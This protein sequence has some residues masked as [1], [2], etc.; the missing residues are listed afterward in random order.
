MKRL[1]LMNLLFLFF[2]SLTSLYATSVFAQEVPEE[3]TD[4]DDKPKTPVKRD[5]IYVK[6]M[7]QKALVNAPRTKVPSAQIVARPVYV[8]ADQEDDSDSSEWLYS[9]QT[10]VQVC[11]V[12]VPS[13]QAYKEAQDIQNR[14]AA[15]ENSRVTRVSKGIQSAQSARRQAFE[16]CQTRNEYVK[17]QGKSSQAMYGRYSQGSEPELEDC[18]MEAYEKFESLT[19]GL[20]TDPEEDSNPSSANPLPSAKLT[21]C[22]RTADMGDVKVLTAPPPTTAGAKAAKNKT[23]LQVKTNSQEEE[24]DQGAKSAIYPNVSR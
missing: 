11:Q 14:E 13:M 5:P 10:A 1:K 6:D 2:A 15:R 20:H 21:R 3:V 22:K 18:E 8:G 19:Q 9:V 12:S 16:N 23:N 7:I 4:F 17:A 24:D